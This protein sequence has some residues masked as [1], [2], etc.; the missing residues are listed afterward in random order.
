MLYTTY[1]F[2]EGPLEVFLLYLDI[3]ILSYRTT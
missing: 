2:K 1:E 3:F